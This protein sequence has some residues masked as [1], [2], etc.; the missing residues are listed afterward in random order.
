MV[1]GENIGKT[2]V[3]YGLAAELQQQMPDTFSAENFALDMSNDNGI[4]AFR[5]DL[6]LVKLSG[7]DRYP[8]LLVRHPGKKTILISG[9]KPFEVLANAI[10]ELL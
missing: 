5:E 1:K 10:E 4:E 6:N 7:I 8:S 3:L 2:A 9:Y